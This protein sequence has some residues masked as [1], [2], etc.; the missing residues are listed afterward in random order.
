MKELLDEWSS[1]YKLDDNLRWKGA[2]ETQILFAR[3]H[4]GGLFKAGLREDQR[5]GV[6]FVIGTH[7]S[8]SCLLPV[9]SFEREG[10]RLVA[11][12]NFFNWKFSVISDRPIEADFS[13]LFHTSPPVDLD[14]TGDPLA[15]VYFEGFPSDL[16]FGYYDDSDKRTWSAEI[17]GDQP[18][19]ASLYL[20]MRALGHIRP[21]EWSRRAVNGE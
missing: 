17:W 21:L 11:R 15:P 3:Y 9:Y 20:I 18:A 1:R 5:E 13:G 16:I 10:L 19:W 7:T 2:S 8:K 14:Y 6:S 4:L 12:E